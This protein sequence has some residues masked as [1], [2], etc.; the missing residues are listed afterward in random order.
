MNSQEIFEQLETDLKFT[1]PSQKG[2]EH[3]LDLVL[4]LKNQVEEKLQRWL[5][6]LETDGID[7]KNMVAV[8]IQRLLEEIK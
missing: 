1:A 4:Q 5:E 8:D 3:I 6:L 7:S 2:Y